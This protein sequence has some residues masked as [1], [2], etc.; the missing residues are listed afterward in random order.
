MS[1]VAFNPVWLFVLIP[2][3][4]IVIFPLMWILVVWLISLTSGWQ[5][6]AERYPATQPATGRKWLGQFGLVNRAR[7]SNVLNL[8]TDDT[9]V[10]IEVIPL[11]R[12]N[13]PPLFI[14]WHEIHSPQPVTFR[15][16]QLVQVDVGHPRVATLRLPHE[17]FQQSPIGTNVP[18]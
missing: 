10:W 3:A 16:H 1:E 6:L 2:L 9:G 14:P 7:Y 8:T 4:L 17:V 11:F 18:T 15:W 13:H 5:Q 12:I